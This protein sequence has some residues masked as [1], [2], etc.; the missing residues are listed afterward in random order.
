MNLKGKTV[1]VVIP[2]FNEEKSIGKV[3]QGIPDWVAEVVVVDNNST[4]ATFAVI[5]ANGATALK[6]P[7]QGYG[8][9]C[10]RG[11]QYLKETQ[12]PDI[13]VFMD[14][15]HSDHP[16]DMP[17][18]LQPILNQEADMVIGSRALGEREKGSMTLPQIFGNWLATKLMKWIYGVEFTDLGPFRALPFQKLLD[19]NMED[20]DYGWT[21]EMQ[22]KAA[23]KKYKSIEVPVQYRRRIGVSKVSG[24]LK[25][26]LMAGYKILFTVFKY[27]LK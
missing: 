8:S 7:R 4:D 19:L 10:L 3:I 22:V 27:A 12:A 14:A 21:V 5:Q 13:L 1:K 15:D 11:I 18:L 9:A 20:P 2:A 17:A 25:G 23:K 6:E 16:D 24:T 26:T